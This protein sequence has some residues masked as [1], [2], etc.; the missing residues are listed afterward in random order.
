MIKEEKSKGV[1]RN[2]LNEDC[3]PEAWPTE[4]SMIEEVG[5][6]QS[7][8]CAIHDQEIKSLIDSKT[9]TPFELLLLM[10]LPCLVSFAS[11]LGL[12]QRRK[13]IRKDTHVPH[14][15]GPTESITNEAIHKEL[16][17]RLV[18]AATT[19]SNLEAKHDSVPRNCGGTTAQTRFERVSEHS[20]DSLLA[21]GRRVNDI[22]A[23]EDITLVSAADNVMFDVS[24]ATTTITI[25]TEEITLAQALEALK[26]SK[27]KVKWIVF[28]VPVK[29]TITTTIISSQ[30]SLDKGKGIMI[31]EPV[32]PK[33]KDQSRLD[34]E[35][36]KK[37]QAEF[38][39]EERL[40]RKKA[41]KEKRTNIA[42]VEK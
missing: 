20:N 27:P 3:V 14:P 1:A 34:E 11:S 30:Q 12:I 6:Q 39:E 13:P 42:L 21:R 15:S 19:A 23:D 8:F 29:Y 25:T 5:C 33:E 16:G 28:Q 35:V 36:V 18:R 31:E 38:D 40:E 22:D 41:E 2:L 10:T 4:S 9:W 32:K 26:T 37:L 17:N 7:L 24:T